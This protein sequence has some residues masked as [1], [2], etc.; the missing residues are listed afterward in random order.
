MERF[1]GETRRARASKD[2]RF[3]IQYGE[4]YSIFNFFKI[5]C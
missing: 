4:I 1:I 3:K 2:T 5:F